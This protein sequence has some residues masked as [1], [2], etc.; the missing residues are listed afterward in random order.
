MFSLEVLTGDQTILMSAECSH[1]VGSSDQS[2]S[3]RV[4]TLMAVICPCHIGWQLKNSTEQMRKGHFRCIL[5]D[6]FAIYESS[7]EK[8]GNGSKQIH[9]ILLSFKC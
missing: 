8:Q 7:G 6:T 2:A 4:H 5:S 3:W 1:W 9:N